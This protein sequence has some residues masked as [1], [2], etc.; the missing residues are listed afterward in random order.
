MRSKA[1]KVVL[2]WRQM[3]ALPYLATAPTEKEG[4]RRAKISQDTY[5]AWLK[6]PL[7]KSEIRKFREDSMNEAIDLA[8][9]NLKLAIEK[10][11]SLIVQDENK[12]IMRL[13][14][15]DL[16]NIVFKAKDE[17]MKKRLDNL[18]RQVFNIIDPEL[19]K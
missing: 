15:N 17:E 2:T 1:E 9:A 18:E 11:I 13:A 12:G 5:Y 10:I 14:C 16:V 4:C 6:E 8:K 19:P 7:F 3:Q